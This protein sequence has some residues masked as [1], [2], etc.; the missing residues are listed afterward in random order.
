MKNLPNSF[1]IDENNRNINRH[2][3]L[4]IGQSKVVFG[5]VVM[6]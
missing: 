1:K 5:D 6:A 2:L 4:A 3:G